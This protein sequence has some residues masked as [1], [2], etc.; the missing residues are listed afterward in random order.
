MFSELNYNFE[1]SLWEVTGLCLNNE[2]KHFPD[3]LGIISTV[4][5]LNTHGREIH[6]FYIHAAHGT[7]WKK[8]GVRC[9]KDKG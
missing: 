9:S 4:F 7:L 3:Q 5:E 2:S 6:S 1:E 8:P